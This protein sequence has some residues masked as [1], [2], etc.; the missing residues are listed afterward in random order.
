MTTKVI[1]T[2]IH[3]SFCGKSEEEVE[4]L[5]AAPNVLICDKCVNLCWQ[6][7]SGDAIKIDSDDNKE[8]TKWPSK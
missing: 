8:V 4:R 3:C 2:H 7:L 1:I 5:I 6:I